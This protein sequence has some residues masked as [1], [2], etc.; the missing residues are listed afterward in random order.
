MISTEKVYDM[1]PVVTVLYDKLDLDGYRK[2]FIKEN[3]GKKDIDKNAI[4][5][6]V[7]KH[8]LKNSQKVKEEIFEVVAIFEEQTVEE[9]KAQSFMKTLNSLKEIFSDKETVDFLK[10]AI[11]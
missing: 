1:L 8:I 4:G 11:V 10:Q 7:F 6:D 3:K 5:I 9:V 2:K